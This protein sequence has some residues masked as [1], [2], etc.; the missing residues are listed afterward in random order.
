MG[1]KCRIT[2]L[3]WL[4]ALAVIQVPATAQ[5]ALRS[6]DVSSCRRFAQD[7]YSWYLPLI[8]QRRNYPTSDIAIQRKA[9]VFEPA[10]LRA[11]KVDSVAQR[12]ANGEIVGIDFDP[13]VGSDGAENYELRKAYLHGDR[14]LVEVWQTPPNDNSWKPAK[15]DV[16]AELSK[17]AG[18]WQF[19]NFFYPDANGSNGN[20]DL[21]SALAWWREA[22]G[23]QQ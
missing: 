9:T 19:R 4:L 17:Q 16:I 11:L 15:P 13:F 23:K 1:I 7:F 12:R 14:C 2:H 8:H 22:R 18:H 21:I 6:E 10:L 20:S 5:D 3:V